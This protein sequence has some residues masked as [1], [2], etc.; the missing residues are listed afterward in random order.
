MDS[1]NLLI[2]APRALTGKDYIMVHLLSRLEV[3]TP[4]GMP[5]LVTEI[6]RRQKSESSAVLC[7]VS[8]QELFTLLLLTPQSQDNFVSITGSL[9]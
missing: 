2:P 3:Q 7:L 9:P 4:V 1:E 5:F 6:H 8:H